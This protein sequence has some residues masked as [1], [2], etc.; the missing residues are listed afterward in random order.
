M[1]RLGI[2][3]KLI[4]TI[5]WFY[6]QTRFEVNGKEVPI[7]AGVIQGGVLSPTLFIIMFNDLIQ[8]LEEKGFKVYA[9]AD[10]LCILQFSMRRLKKAIWIVEKWTI[11]NKMMINK[12]KS[13][14]IFF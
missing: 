6:R 1:G 3:D 10:D 14:V 8:E 13:G 12:S 11:A 7:G 9:Y 2:D 4:N 5:K